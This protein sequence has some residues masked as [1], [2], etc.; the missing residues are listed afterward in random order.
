M[1]CSTRGRAGTA[2][3]LLFVSCAHHS[4]TTSRRHDIRAEEARKIDAASSPQP[5]TQPHNSC[6]AAVS[7]L[8]LN[9][10]CTSFNTWSSWG[11][12][13][14]VDFSLFIHSMCLTSLRVC[15]VFVLKLCLCK[16]M[17]RLQ[18]ASVAAAA[19][20]QACRPASARE[21]LMLLWL[22]PPV[23]WCACTGDAGVVCVCVN[24]HQ[25]LKCQAARFIQVA[26]PS[27][28]CSMA[29]YLISGGTGYVP[30]DGLSAQ[31]LFSIGDGLTYK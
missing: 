21:L 26:S 18:L 4:I 29:D 11:D 16:Q 2:A 17:R 6:E 1:F 30:E 25:N 10:K 22:C 24:K 14:D 31:Q 7:A 28:L 3:L 5:E 19:A 9:V 15:F 27:H 20:A 12:L 8:H 13:W 23:W